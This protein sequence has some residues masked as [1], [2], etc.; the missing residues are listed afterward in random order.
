[1]LSFKKK[2]IFTRWWFLFHWLYIFVLEIYY[3]F[4][5]HIL[6]PGFKPTSFRFEM[7][8]KNVKYWKDLSMHPFNLVPQ[9]Y[10]YSVYTNYKLS[11]PSF[12]SYVHICTV[13]PPWKKVLYYQR[14]P[15]FVA[16]YSYYSM[17]LVLYDTWPAS[18][19]RI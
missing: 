19:L 9:L 11:H 4:I 3:L 10:L 17:E 14:R 1:M 15:V 7:K 2:P 8:K 6:F 18:P 16:V 5:I 13:A 12:L